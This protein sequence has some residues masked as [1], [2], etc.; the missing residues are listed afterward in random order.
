MELLERMMGNVL[1]IFRPKL[2]GQTKYAA[3]LDY[4]PQELN[5]VSENVNIAHTLQQ[6]LDDM[7]RIGLT[8]LIFGLTELAEQAPISKPFYED[9]NAEKFTYFADYFERFNQPNKGDKHIEP[10]KSYILFALA[11]YGKDPGQQSLGVEEIIRE[12]TEVLPHNKSASFNYTYSGVFH[13]ISDLTE[14]T[15]TIAAKGFK[16]AGIQT[17]IREGL[18]DYQKK[19]RL[20]CQ[21]TKQP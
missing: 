17:S 13:P 14:V 4:I 20:A 19:L 11:I 10:G 9:S 16:T 3:P 18:L 15:Q 8:R 21:P 6:G 7:Q 5:P 1:T 2:S 12:Y